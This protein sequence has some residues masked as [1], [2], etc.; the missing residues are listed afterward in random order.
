MMQ[1][2]G[3]TDIP[4]VLNQ[5]QII[6]LQR[7]NNQILTKNILLTDNQS[8]NVF[9]VNALLNSNAHLVSILET[10]KCGK[11]VKNVRN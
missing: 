8:F 10:F 11:E 6:N 1:I 7:L 9:R 3:K 4:Y 5:P 2:Y